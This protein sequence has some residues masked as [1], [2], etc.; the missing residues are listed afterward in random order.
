[1]EYW[2]MTRIQQIIADQKLD[3]ILP[4]TLWVRLNDKIAGGGVGKE[5]LDTDKLLPVS[6]RTL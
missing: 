6:L 2:A 5:G 1:M 3:R 4:I